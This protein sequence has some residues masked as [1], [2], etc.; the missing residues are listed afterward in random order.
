MCTILG[1]TRSLVYYRP[2]DKTEHEKREQEIE[3][4]VKRE[5]ASSR[6]NYGTRKLKVMLE[7]NAGLVVSR[8]KIGRIMAKN[9][10]ESSYTK[11]HYKVRK[12][13]AVNEE[14]A[15]NLLNRQFDGRKPL[16]A[17][18]SD[19]T[20]VRVGSKWNYICLLLDLCNREIIGYA[21]GENKNAELVKT[22]FYS[23][24]SSLADIEIFHTDRGSEFKNEVIDEIISI[25]GMKRSLSLKGTP[26]DN[27]VAEAMYKTIKTEFIFGKVF[28]TIE[29]LDLQLF[30][31]VNWFNNFRIHA[32]LNYRSPF[33]HKFFVLHN[34]V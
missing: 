19:L 22:A 31:Y 5:F 21:V 17:V 6:R 1:V 20:Y 28:N 29:D 9:G 7:R 4:A 10:L 14:Q 34:S 8:R 33:Q 32:S 26:Y 30:D 23:V 2:K 24:K 12:K 3:T 16:E 18:V 27:A 25:F 13:G 11:K 15:P